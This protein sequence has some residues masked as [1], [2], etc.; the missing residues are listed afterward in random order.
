M[1]RRSMAY[2]GLAGVGM[3]LAFACVAG[4]SVAGLTVAGTTGAWAQA[5]TEQTAPDSAKPKK[6]AATKKAPGSESAEAGQAG[7]KPSDPA[8]VQKA[9][10]AAQKSLDAGKADVALNQANSL[11]SAGGLEPRAMARALALRGHANKK[12]AKPAQAIADLQSALWLAGGLSEPERAAALQARSEAY[13]EAGLGDAPPIAAAKAAKATANSGTSTP[14]ATAAVAPRPA[15]TV[16]APGPSQAG[17]VGNFFSN[18]FGGS[19]SKAATAPPPAQASVPVTPSVS[20]WSETTQ[21]TPAKPEA[22]PKPQ[23]AKATPSKVASAATQAGQT[24]TGQSEAGATTAGQFRLQLGA[25]RSRDE[26]Q[27][28]AQRV[29][30]E[31]GDKIGQ[32]TYDIDETV[33]GN[34]GTFYR[35]RI[36]P[37]AE[38]SEPKGLCQALRGKGVDCMLVSN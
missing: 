19:A 8:A 22:K 20:S 17:G 4:L 11:I 28:V 25:V 18:L 32:R 30:Q 34:M 5:V 2:A 23:A 27:A 3:T 14:I 21:T 26:A 36:G 24:Q 37:F 7:K 29:K 38:A 10:D 33:F 13:R 35:V 15:E 12:L 1:F 6:K 9:L 16:T 31:F